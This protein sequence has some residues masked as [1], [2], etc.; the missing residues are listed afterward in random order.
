MGSVE[1]LSQLSRELFGEWQA[2]RYS[3]TYDRQPYPRVG[4]RPKLP[5]DASRPPCVEVPPTDAARDGVIVTLA[6]PM[7]WDDAV[8]LAGLGR[9]LAFEAA[10]T[11][12]GDDRPWTC[13]GPVEERPGLAVCEQL[14]VEPQGITALAGYVDPGTGASLRADPRV[15]RVD[16]LRDPVE[17]LIGDLG[18]LDTDPPDLTI[19]DAWWEIEHPS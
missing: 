15:A 16:G 4:D 13:G 11:V 14:G 10:A 2:E 6:A 12:R 7:G 18:G 8:A 5:A 9:W 3:L 1:V 17:T 19:N